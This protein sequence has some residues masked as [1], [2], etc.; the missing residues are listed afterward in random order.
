[1]LLGLSLILAVMAGMAIAVAAD[2]SDTSFHS[3]DDLRAFTKVPILAS[4]PE[5]AATRPAARARDFA[6]A[7]ARLV[8]LGALALGAFHLAHYGDRVVRVLSR[9]G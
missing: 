1:M 2:W 5:I 4:I 7:C 8:V 6:L 3:V 9:V